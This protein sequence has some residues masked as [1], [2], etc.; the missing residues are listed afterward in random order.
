[1][2]K[3]AVNEAAKKEFENWLAKRAEIEKGAKAS[4]MWNEMGL[5]AN[6]HLFRQINNETKAKLSQLSALVKE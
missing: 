1:M 5:D 6:T 3:N 4:G 2:D